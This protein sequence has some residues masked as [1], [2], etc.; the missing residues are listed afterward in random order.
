MFFGLGKQR[1]TDENKSIYLYAHIGNLSIN[2]GNGWCQLNLRRTSF[3]C[4]GVPPLL[5]LQ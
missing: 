5:L 4:F 1:C 2:H 3:Q